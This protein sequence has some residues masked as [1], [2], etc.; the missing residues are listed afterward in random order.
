MRPLLFQWR[1][2]KISSYP[3]MLYLGLVFGVVA[4]NIAAHAAHINALRVYLATLIL[5][6]PALA[7]AR[8]LYVAT[9]WRSYQHDLRR[10]W[11]RREGGCSMY[12]GLLPML[13]LSFPLLRFLQLSFGAFWDVASFTI[14][15]AMIVTRVGCLMNGCCAGRPSQSWLSFFLPGKNGVWQRRI[16]TQAFEAGWAVTLL[17]GAVVFW[18]AMPF[19]GALFLFVVLA[20]AAGRFV[21]DVFRETEF[22]SANFSDAQAISLMAA[23]TSISALTIYWR[24]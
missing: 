15:V 18:P 17:V 14:L 8:L 9:H 3:A 4:G 13:L 22:R 1:G 16:P 19:P 23:F 2:L 20:Y 21:M 11:N 6:G 10:V 12:G 7:G 5:T 24:H